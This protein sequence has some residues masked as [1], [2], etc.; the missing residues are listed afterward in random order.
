MLV[1]AG[2]FA[3][4][5][6][7]LIDIKDCYNSEI[8]DF[9][10]LFPNRDEVLKIINAKIFEDKISTN[11]DSFLEISDPF[12]YLICLKLVYLKIKSLSTEIVQIYSDELGNFFEI[13]TKY[14]NKKTA[15]KTLITRI[16]Y[17]VLFEHHITIAARRE[18]D[19]L[20][21]LN[22]FFLSG[23]KESKL[24]LNDKIIKSGDSFTN[25]KTI[26]SYFCYVLDRKELF[27]Y[28]NTDNNFI[29]N[30][31]KKILVELSNVNKDNN[32]EQILLITKVYVILKKIAPDFDFKFFQ[33]RL[34]EI[35]ENLLKKLKN[36]VKDKIK[37]ILISDFSDEDNINIENL[38]KEIK[39]TIK[40]SEKTFKGEN[41]DL[42]IKNYLEFVE[43]YFLLHIKN[44]KFKSFEANNFKKESN[45]IAYIFK[46]RNFNEKISKVAVII[47]SDE[48][49]LQIVVRAT[50]LN[51]DE[52]KVWLKCREDYKSVKK[53]IQDFI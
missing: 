45:K 7:Y 44:F 17:N 39:D 16:N 20:N 46:K 10:S 37:K 34:S 38:L 50:E 49:I 27:G 30:K 28:D 52:I 41:G 26:I 4:F 18:I 14:F 5:F 19:C 33:F 12:V 43:E 51:V 25:F 8:Y 31:F 32:F 13:D 23:K 9:V 36:Q 48:S 15:R 11:L 3:K 2:T 47:S 29:N 22:S 42:F 24:I 6:N 40:K 53:V 21:Y 1:R 35:F